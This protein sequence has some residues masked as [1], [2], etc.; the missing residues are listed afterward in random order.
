LEILHFEFSLKSMESLILSQKRLAHSILR[1]IW[2]ILGW[3]VHFFVHFHLLLAPSSQWFAII[4]IFKA[5]TT[6][7]IIVIAL[8][9]AIT[10]MNYPWFICS[11]Q[12]NW[13]NFKCNIYSELTHQWA[14]HFLASKRLEIAI[15][16]AI[17]TK[18]IHIIDFIINFYQSTQ[19]STTPVEY[20]LHHWYWRNYLNSAIK[21]TITIIIV[22]TI[23]TT[24][25]E[26]I[27]S[28]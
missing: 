24:R 10:K 11:S 25:K 12:V 1:T 13:S 9:A 17:T 8:V 16:K 18:L 15:T 27:V 26:L 23:E 3:R 14:R 21:I 2:H 5:A 4:A 6:E 22:T 20:S 19:I 7:A 28:E